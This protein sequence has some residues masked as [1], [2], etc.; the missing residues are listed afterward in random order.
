MNTSIKRT[1]FALLL[2]SLHASVFAEHPVSNSVLS[3][4]EPVPFD[5]ALRFPDERRLAPA[6]SDFEITS[7]LM[8][9]S[10]NGERWATVSIRNNSAHQR[11]FD[12][13]HII[14]VFADGDKRH[15]LEVQQKFS[16]HE[17]ITLT[18]NFGFSK[19]PILRLLTRS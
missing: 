2:T 13:T 8:M 15:P 12:H 19:F 5:N 18:I 11:L 3:I 17:E 7:R 1:T 14:A 6:I 9:S 10:D 16:G 4:D